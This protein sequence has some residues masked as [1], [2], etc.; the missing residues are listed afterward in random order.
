MI[1]FR[2][3]FISW[4]IKAYL[5]KWGKQILLYF[6]IGLFVF[7]VSRLIFESVAGKIRVLRTETIGMLGAYSTEDLPSAISYKI[8]RGLTTVR[9]DGTVKPDVAS[10]WK[11]KNNGKT[12]I[13]YLRRNIFFSD[14]TKFT[15]NDV[16][17]NFADVS[18]K[19]P[20][21]YT[22]EYSLKDSYSPFLITVSK[23]IFKKG[24]IGVSDYRVKDIKLNGNFVEHIDLVSKNGNKV[25]YQFYPTISA[26]KI[27]FALGEV[28]KI[29][30]MPDVDFRNT[31]FYTFKNA[32]VDKKPNYK[33]LTTLFYNTTDKLLSSKTIREALSYAIP[34]NFDEGVR[35]FG[36]FPPFSFASE[37]GVDPRRLDLE[38]A[39]LL[40]D[41]AREAG[42]AAEKISLTIET[43]A[44][45]EDIAEVIANIWKSLNI[46]VDIKPVDKVPQAFQ[47]FLGEFN[48]PQDVDQYMLWHSDQQSNITRYINLRVDKLLEDGRKEVD[49]EKRKK[50]YADF[51]KFIQADPPA[52]FLFFPYTYDVTRK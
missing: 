22:I 44:K 9:R 28:S 17:Y 7:F 13:F 8:S 37:R 50:I 21:N 3:R 45:Y 23:P 5:K 2:H 40:L 29:V 12:Y 43:L 31:T 26:L 19:R 49:I 51:Q 46:D 14:G 32:K 15:S 30:D 11:I 27:A 39:K 41:K 20:D 4:L 10:K 35:S 48:L 1:T 33:R 24:L 42:E 52:S 25:I 36:P 38:H 6:G 34:D 18:V 16:R 47:I